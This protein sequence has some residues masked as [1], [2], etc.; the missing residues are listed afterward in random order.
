MRLLHGYLGRSL[1]LKGKTW[2]S[3]PLAERTYSRIKKD[4]KFATH[5]SKGAVT[6]SP[7]EDL[8]LGLL[9]SETIRLATC[10][11]ILL[12]GLWCAGRGK[13]PVK[14]LNKHVTLEKDRTV[15]GVNRPRVSHNFLIDK[16]HNSADAV[17]RSDAQTLE[18]SVECGCKHGTNHDQ[19]NRLC[20]MSGVLAFFEHKDVV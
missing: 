9:V 2:Q 11:F 3:F 17:V 4:L 1:L 8:K 14:T 10:Q 12:L 18:K 15:L 5:K 6:L 20:Q 13:D 16:T 19:Q 7:S